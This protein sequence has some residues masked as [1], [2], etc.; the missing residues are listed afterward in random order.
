MKEIIELIRNNQEIE[1]G[2]AADAR[3][4]MITRTE[5][6]K[7][8]FPVWTT[9]FEQLLAHFNGIFHNGAFIFGLKPENDIFS[10][11]LNE[12]MILCPPEN[13]LFLGYSEWDYLVYDASAQ[14]YQLVDKD[15]LHPVFRGDLAYLLRHFLKL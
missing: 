6:K 8:G 4:V 9:E 15:D 1:H 3:L 14:E 5:L 13:L 2:E 7:N 10:D 12:N 11:L